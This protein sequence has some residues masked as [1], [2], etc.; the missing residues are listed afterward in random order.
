MA[1]PVEVFTTRPTPCACAAREH[2]DRALDVDAGVVRRVGDRLAHVD[3][4]GQVEDD[5]GLRAADHV[6]TP[7]SRVA[8]VDLRERGAVRR[9]RCS[10][11]SRL[12][13]ERSS[14]TVT[15]SPRASERVDEVRSDEAGAAGDESLH[16]AAA[17]RRAAAARAPR[18]G[19][20]RRP[21][22]RSGSSRRSCRSRWSRPSLSRPGSSRSR[23]SRSRWSRSRSSRTPEPSSSSL[24]P[25]PP[26]S[27]NV[28]AVPP[29]PARG[30]DRDGVGRVVV[31]AAVAAPL[32]L[33]AD[34]ACCARRPS[35]ADAGA[36]VSPALTAARRRGRRCRPRSSSRAGRCP[37][38]R[39]GRRWRG[40]HRLRTV[41][42]SS[43]SEA[44]SASGKV[45]SRGG[46][47]L[48]KARTACE[49]HLGAGA[50]LGPVRERDLAAPARGERLDHREAEPRAGGAAA[51][52]RR[53][54]RS[55]GRRARPR[56]GRAPGPR[57]A[58]RAAPSRRRSPR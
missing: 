1:P 32:A 19:V 29:V 14:T 42:R 46:S 16:A 33:R 57:R 18:R 52:R 25:S 31:A 43:R 26:W 40:L 55:A 3:L 47:A 28:V 35:V 38:R 23:R 49:R 24:P 58:P 48:G 5:V 50:A 51:A 20:S 2:V 39:R 10:R 7:P 15:S 17:S 53:R 44:S 45:S 8:D 11:F 4:R 34:G 54:G 6:A 13:V 22:R 30:R 9:A 12:P 41:G 27:S 56:R 21:S 37:P 36:S